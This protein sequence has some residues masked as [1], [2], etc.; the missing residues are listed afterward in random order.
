MKLEIDTG[1]Q[2]LSHV[3]TFYQWGGRL[4]LE[5]VAGFHRNG[6]PL[7]NGISGRLGME[8]M[9]GLGWNMHWDDDEEPYRV[10]VEKELDLV[11]YMEKGTWDEIERE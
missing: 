11:E 5:S 9:A 6:W 2:G 3:A 1:Y 7:S 4:A 10:H 8:Y